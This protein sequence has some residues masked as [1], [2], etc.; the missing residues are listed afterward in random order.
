MGAFVDSYSADEFEDVMNYIT[1][2]DIILD[3]IYQSRRV[4]NKFGVSVPDFDYPEEMQQFLGRKTW[5]DRISH[6]AS[7]HS[8][9]GNFVKTV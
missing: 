4:F 3:G 6:I 5:K 8:T 9:W 2:D 1:K 7:D